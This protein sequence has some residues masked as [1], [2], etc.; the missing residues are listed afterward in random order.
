M[1]APRIQHHVTDAGPP[2]VK[3]VLNVVAMLE[4]RPMMLNAKLICWH[5]SHCSTHPVNHSDRREAA[6]ASMTSR[7]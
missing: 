6:A 1:Q 4:Q 5:K 2:S 7:S 3:G